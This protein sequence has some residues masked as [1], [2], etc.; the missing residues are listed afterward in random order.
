MKIMSS[1]RAS[2]RKKAKKK[3]ESNDFFNFGSICKM[4]VGEKIIVVF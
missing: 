4:V 2:P 3:M 1:L